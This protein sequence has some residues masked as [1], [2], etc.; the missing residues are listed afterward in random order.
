MSTP[1]IL[2]F[3]EK[4]IP[5]DAELLGSKS[6]TKILSCASDIVLEYSTLLK[7]NKDIKD[8]VEQIDTKHKIDM[9][10]KEDEITELKIVE[11]RSKQMNIEFTQLKKKKD[12]IENNVFIELT[13]LQG[14][15]KAQLHAKDL[16]L[17]VMEK[18]IKELK[19][20]D[21]FAV[22]ESD[23]PTLFKSIVRKIN[24]NQVTDKD[25][26][27]TLESSEDSMNNSFDVNNEDVDKNASTSGE[28]NNLFDDNN[29]T[30]QVQNQ[31]TESQNHDGN[32]T[33]YTND[34]NTAPGDNHDNETVE[35]VDEE[36]GDLTQI[37]AE[38]DPVLLNFPQRRFHRDGQE[39]TNLNP[40]KPINRNQIKIKNAPKLYACNY[41]Q[42]NKFRSK[43]ILSEHIVNKHPKNV[44]DLNCLT[45][46]HQQD[47]VKMAK[48]CRQCQIAEQ[49]QRIS[50]DIG[51]SDTG[52]VDQ[53]PIASRT[54]STEP[55]HKR[56]KLFNSQKAGEN[57]F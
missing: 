29:V 27:E 17:Q 30:N 42:L 5:I 2:K 1:H 37:E 46:G 28:G 9:Q 19:S 36:T 4:S 56:I 54:K 26:T 25:K 51:A 44:S 52:D 16:E 7:E 57:I 14:I 47:S 39:I 18:E 41:C 55:T 50:S 43:K 21:A 45:C 33:K 24:S 10:L 8:K 34:D 12:D 32:N 48:Q 53:Y 38:Q 23:F 31:E 13:K 35:N 11:E 6:F 3:H 15:Y 40:L 20:E 49:K 22:T